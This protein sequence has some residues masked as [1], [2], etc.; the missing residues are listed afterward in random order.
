MVVQHDWADGAPCGLHHLKLPVTDVARGRAFYRDALGFVDEVEFREDG[1][2]RG[3]GL[4]HPEGDLGLALRE[5]P[6]RA[7]ALSGFDSVCLAVG[8][9]ADLDAL[10]RRLDAAGFAHTAPVPGYRGWA[11]DVP[12]PDGHLVRVHTLV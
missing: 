8:T 6:V 5:D 4:R 12:D 3:V 2:L 10:L 11:A 7:R 1:V 9:R